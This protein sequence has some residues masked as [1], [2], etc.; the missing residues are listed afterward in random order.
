MS[1]Q[2]IKCSDDETWHVREFSSFRFKLEDDVNTF[3]ELNTKIE[4]MKMS[5]F[6]SPGENCCLIF[7]KRKK[8][9]TA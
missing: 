9:H 2:G 6:S 7:Y 5:F 1:I 8:T 4:I 3:L